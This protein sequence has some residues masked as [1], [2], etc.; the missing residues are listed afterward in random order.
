[1]RYAYSYT[2]E[3]SPTDGGRLVVTAT[4]KDEW[5]E[6]LGA[7]H[8]HPDTDMIV[9][10]L[11]I[12]QSTGEY[13]ETFGSKKSPCFPFTETIGDVWLKPYFKHLKD[14]TGYDGPIPDIQLTSFPTFYLWCCFTDAKIENSQVVCSGYVWCCDWNG[15]KAVNRAKPLAIEAMQSR[16]GTTKSETEFILND[17]GTCYHRNPAWGKA[18]VRIP[19]ASFDGVWGDIANWWLINKATDEQRALL[20]QELDDK[21]VFN[22]N[23][24]YLHALGYMPGYIFVKG[25]PYVSK[26]EF[27]AMGN[28]TSYSPTL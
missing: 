2:D 22:S 7:V 21:V 26:D 20:R 5:G 24:G 11:G 1:M 9:T 13:S 19:G 12:L 23:K 14:L 25:R 16:V 15:R 27:I 28:S 8:F 18:P 17:S 10:T 4:N 3:A 6:L